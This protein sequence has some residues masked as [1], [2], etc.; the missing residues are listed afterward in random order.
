MKNFEMLDGIT[1]ANIT[2]YKKNGFLVVPKLVSETLIEQLRQEATHIVT[3]K[4]GD[5]EGLQ[6]HSDKDTTKTILKKYVAIH[7]PHKISEFIK[8]VAKASKV[9]DILQYLIGT[10]VKCLQT[11]LFIK[12]PGK[13]GQAWHQDEFFIPTR[14]RSLTGVWLAID[15]ADVDNGCLWVVPGSHND[16]IIRKRVPN[17][18][19]NFADTEVADLTPYTEKDFVAVPVKK[20]GVIFFNGYLLHMSLKNKTTDRFRRA[21]VSHYSSAESMLPWDMDGR[22]AATNDFRDIFIV[23]GTD[24]YGYKGT[25]NLAKPFVRPDTVDFGTEAFRKSLDYKTPKA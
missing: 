25:E 10:N 22:V 5:I 9:A 19:S 16:G 2:F 17:S 1:E 13:K 18:D 3:G 21:L 6:N 23:A 4:R 14:D 11:M 12:A 20:G 15:D 8:S 7:F 24:P